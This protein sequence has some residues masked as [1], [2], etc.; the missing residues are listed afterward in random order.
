[1]AGRVNQKLMDEF[2]GLVLDRYRDSKESRASAIGVIGHLIVALDLPEGEGDVP[3]SYM[4][5]AMSE[6]RD[7]DG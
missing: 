3:N 1:M 7:D 6:M 2:L 5:G 4:K